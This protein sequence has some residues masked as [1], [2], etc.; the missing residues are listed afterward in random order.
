MKQR[1]GTRL[2]REENHVFEAFVDRYSL[3]R[4][5]GVRR[6]GRVRRRSHRHHLGAING[7]LITRLNVAPFIATLGTLYVARGLAL[8]SSDG[9]T[10]PNLVGKKELGTTGYGVLGAGRLLGLPVVIWILIAVALAAAYFARFTPVG[11]H[12]FAA[13]S[14][15]RLC[16]A[17]ASRGSRC[18]STCFPAFAPR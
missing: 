1:V 6:D 3:G 13:M 10:F 12:I 14:G 16:R 4:R 2:E 7:V 5:A 9:A 11:R 8:L 18:S 15:R 17:F